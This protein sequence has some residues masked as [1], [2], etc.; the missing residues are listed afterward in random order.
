MIAFK[1]LLATVAGAI[2][3]LPTA[4][5]L[6]S[7]TSHCNLQANFTLIAQAP[8]TAVD[9]WAVAANFY[10]N[11]LSVSPKDPTEAQQDNF[12]PVTFFKTESNKNQLYMY[13]VSQRTEVPALM[14]LL[15]QRFFDFFDSKARF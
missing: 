6:P 9:G 1:P 12:A 5:G 14:P 4:A 10:S 11:Y 13:L 15:I 7:T 3:L 2:S 8:G